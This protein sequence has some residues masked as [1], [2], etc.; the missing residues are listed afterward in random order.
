MNWRDFQEEAAELF[1]GLG[2]EAE[3]EARVQ[4]ARATH[5]IDVWVTFTRHGIE[6]KWAVECKH[7]KAKVSKDKVLTLKTLIEDVG[8]DR[9]IIISNSGFQPGATAAAAN[10]NITLTSLKEAKQRAQLHIGNT[11]DKEPPNTSGQ[12]PYIERPPIEETCFRA[13]LEPGCLIRIKA[14]HYRGKTLLVAKILEFAEDRGYRSIFLDIQLSDAKHRC[15][16]SDLLRWFC[17]AAAEELGLPDETERYWTSSCNRNATNYFRNYLL[18][19]TDGMLVMAIDNVDLIFENYI[20]AVD[21]CS[22][23]RGWNDNSTHKR[24]GFDRMALIIAHST[25]V[26]SVVNINQSYLWNAGIPIQI[27]EFNSSQVRQLAD[28]YQPSLSDKELHKLTVLLGGNPFLLTKAFESI[29]EGRM[30]LEELLR[31]AATESG[32][33]GDYLRGHLL[34]L[35]RHPDLLEVFRTLLLAREPARI[36]ATDRFHL[37]RMGLVDLVGNSIVISCDLYRQY[38]SDVLGAKRN[39]I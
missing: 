28:H 19:R 26:Y 30:T 29:D 13:I 5:D 32:P 6:C 36:E 20:V 24:F 22:L 38:F 9:G 12:A 4:G 33:Y 2:C 27:P 35:E 34:S 10:T 15:D 16:L 3:V 25:E 1:R 39:E 17:A 18:P 14:P 8:A 23:L 11:E 37:H 31:T 7:W 21:F